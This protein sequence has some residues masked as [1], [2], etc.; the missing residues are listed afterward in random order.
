M[1]L[2][3]ILLRHGQSIWNVEQRF[4]GWTDVALTELGEAQARAAGQLLRRR[5]FLFDAVWTSELQRARRTADLALAEIGA[6]G[7]TRQATTRLNERNFGIL[8]GM[9]FEEAARIHGPE[10]GQPW[11]W[12]L[13]PEGGESL[14]DLADR[15]QPLLDGQIRPALCV[16]RVILVVAHGNT[17]RVLDELLRGGTGARLETVPAAT[18]LMYELDEGS[19]SVRERVFLVD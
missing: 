4:T 17:I 5:R 3:L 1:S 14:E 18:P 2:R 10:W 8:E 12:G 19:M 16:G 9:K 11:L 6:N 15:V 7:G 13:R